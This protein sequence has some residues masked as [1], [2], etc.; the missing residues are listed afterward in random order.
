MSNSST[1]GTEM[2]SLLQELFP[3][4]RSLTGDGV[5]KTLSILQRHI[6]LT[7]SEVPSGTKAFDWTVP[8]EWNV[9][10]A[11]VLDPTGRK[12]IDFKRNN[13][14]LLS[15]SEP[16]KGKLSLADLKEHLYTLK[17]DPDLIP[18]VTSYYKRRWGFCLSH[19]ELCK[20]IEGEYYVEIDSTLKPGSLTYAELVIP[21]LSTKEILISTYVC[22][23]SMANNELSGPIV[24]TFLAQRLLQS[25]VKHTYTYRFVFIPE[26]IGSIIYISKHL[27][28]LRTNVVGG[29]VVT[30]IGDP[31]PFS[32]LMTPSENALVDRITLHVLRNSNQ[33]FNLYNFTTR[34]SDERQY[35]APGVDLNIGSLMRSKYGNYKEYHTSG[36]NLAFV[37]P[38]ALHGSVEM[39][40]RCLSVFEQNVTYRSTML[41][42]PQLGKRGL[43]P[44][45]STRE[46]GVAVRSMT[47]LLAYSDGKRDLLEIAERTKTPVWE[48]YAPAQQLV[49]HG[50]LEKV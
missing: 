49:G 22:H 23:P 45:I 7:I 28:E 43:Y 50:L 4:C 26:T 10:D 39:Y 38:E 16:F 32:Y 12:I 19:N 41:C 24:S 30:C 18:Y 33:H 2:Y 29:Y 25:P 14:H 3:I 37:T 17:D 20:L 34:G 9:R 15:Y 47:N 36:D 46:S 13:L 35:N 48:Y 40:E 27:D 1:L 11:F 8:D 31:A 42:E 6:P 21:G 44:T 5:R